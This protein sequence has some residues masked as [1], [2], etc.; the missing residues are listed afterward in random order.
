MSDDSLK[1]RRIEAFM[2]RDDAI[3]HTPVGLAG[4]DD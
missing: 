3:D 2:T 4:F 1:A